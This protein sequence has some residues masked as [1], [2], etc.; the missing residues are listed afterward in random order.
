MASLTS[1]GIDNV[2][3]VNHCATRLRLTLNDESK[4]NQDKI[5]SVSG[6]MGIVS[7]GKEIQIIIGTDVGNVYAEFI[8]LGDFK[9][10]E[11]VNKEGG[12]VN[13]EG[14]KKLLCWENRIIL[15]K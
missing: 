8:K 5:K 15:T 4:V 11:K 6:V 12:K 3:V 10:A 2:S 14:K 13:E 9:K 1:L 7:R